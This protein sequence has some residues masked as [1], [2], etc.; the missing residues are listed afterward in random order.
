MRFGARLEVACKRHAREL[1]RVVRAKDLDEMRA[2][3]GRDP[4]AVVRASINRSLESYAVYAGGDLLCVF[5][6]RALDFSTHGVW[7]LTTIHVDRHSLT[8][9]KCSKAVVSYLRD[10]YPLMWNMIH[11][12]YSEAL[13]WARRLGF[14]LG[15]PEPFGP[16]GDL[17]CPAALETRRVELTHV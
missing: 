14:V 17:F 9:W 1:A 6:V 5:G 16:R 2:T 8:F 13:R 11:G 4:E 10:R 3:G 15:A 12:K 7:V